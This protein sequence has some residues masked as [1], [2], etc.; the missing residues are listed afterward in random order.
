MSFAVTVLNDIMNSLAISIL[1]LPMRDN[2][3]PTLQ[4]SF[5]VFLLICIEISGRNAFVVLTMP[6]IRF[7]VFFEGNLRTEFHYISHHRLVPHAHSYVEVFS[8]PLKEKSFQ[9]VV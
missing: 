7:V 8:L 1:L 4:L 2:M 9:F 5:Y 3:S 6:K